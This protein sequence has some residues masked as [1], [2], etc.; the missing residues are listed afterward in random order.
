M[1]VTYT[2]VLVL[3]ASYEPVHICGA[4]R[5]II[6]LIK[7]IAKAEELTDHVVRSPS[8]TIRV[9]S[10]IRLVEYVRVPFQRREF[11]K[12]TIYMRDNYTCQYCG[13]SYD[14]AHLT[15]D[16]ILP[17]SRGGRS[18]WEN[19]VTCCIPCNLKKGNQTPREAGMTLISKPKPSPVHFHLQVVRFKGR[20]NEAWKKY[21]YYG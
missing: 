21:L 17:V 12:R 11:S 19:L 4:R 10:V 1:D 5:A 7:G 2:Q 15:L 14:P 9:P 20:H 3:N 6:L 18:V 8:T 13:K 16:H